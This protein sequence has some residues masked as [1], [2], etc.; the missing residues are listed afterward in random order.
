M[1]DMQEQSN[2]ENERL[3]NI[4][5]LSD[6]L[7]RDVSRRL[8]EINSHINAI[9]LAIEDIIEKYNKVMD[10]RDEVLLVTLLR[11]S[12]KY[13]KQFSVWK[14]FLNEDLTMAEQITSILTCPEP[15]A[16]V[17]SDSNIE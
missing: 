8:D 11:I 12:K 4:K 3:K 15:K 7:V 2:T 1:C 16:E 17:E 6:I 14:D 10:D 13:K 9:D 5:I